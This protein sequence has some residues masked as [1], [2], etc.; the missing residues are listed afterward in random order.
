MSVIET[1]RADGFSRDDV[2]DVLFLKID[3]VDVSIPVEGLELLGG[4]QVDGDR[5]QEGSREDRG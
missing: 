3:H 4:F 2:G 1:L 5:D